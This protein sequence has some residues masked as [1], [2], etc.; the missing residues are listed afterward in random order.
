MGNPSFTSSLY[1]CATE[2][3]LLRMNHK[4]KNSFRS[5]ICNDCK[6]YISNYIDADPRHVKLF[7]IEAEMRAGAIKTTCETPHFILIICISLCLLFAWISYSQEKERNELFI[8]N[9]RAPAHV[10][11]AAQA[12]SNSNISEHAN[13]D[14][15][16]RIVADKLNQKTDV[17]RDGKINCIDAAVTFYKYYPDKNKV[18]IEIN[19]NPKTG[20]NHLFNC[21]YT[22]G[23]WKAIEPQT[24]F[25][26]N[27]N[28]LMRA[29]WGSQ[30]DNK[31]NKDETEKWKVYVK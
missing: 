25:S 12:I 10:V 7:M 2:C 20:M 16:L 5:Y 13:I 11:T 4:C 22:D 28:Y 17:N 8:N 29:A 19:V 30:Y 14:K 21:V 24:Y 6:Y 9:Y 26:N 27:K 1:N 31:Y 23:V 18:C 15:T 3:A